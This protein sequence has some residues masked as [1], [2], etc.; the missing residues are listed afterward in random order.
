VQWGLVDSFL[1]HSWLDPLNDGAIY[2]VDR[3]GRLDLADIFLML[4]VRG[5]LRA[6]PSYS[7]MVPTSIVANASLVAPA[8]SVGAVVSRDA[9]T[10]LCDGSNSAWA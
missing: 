9:A 1:S 8:N 4:G 3:A 10:T 5:K 7:A 2:G 6:I